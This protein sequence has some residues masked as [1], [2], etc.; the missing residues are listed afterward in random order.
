MGLNVGDLDGDPVRRLGIGI[1]ASD[2]VG[3]VTLV[4]VIGS[5]SPPISTTADVIP[6]L[7]SPVLLVL[8]L[9]SNA[10]SGIFTIIVPPDDADVPDPPSATPSLPLVGATTAPANFGNIVGDGLFVGS[11]GTRTLDV[12]YSVGAADTGCCVGYTDGSSDFTTVG[13]SDSVGD[14]EG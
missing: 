6:P 9:P 7:P 3:P 10:P 2:A 5:S 8:S 12:G 1:G 4:V 13:F 14:D 11:F